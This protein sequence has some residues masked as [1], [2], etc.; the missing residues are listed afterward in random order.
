M[1]GGGAAAGRDGGVQRDGERGECDGQSGGRRG[2][3]PVVVAGA[4]LGGGPPAV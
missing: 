3:L 2:D 1:H 4:D